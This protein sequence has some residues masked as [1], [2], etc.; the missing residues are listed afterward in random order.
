[1]VGVVRA[2]GC[3]GVVLH[4]ERRDVQAAQALDDVVVETDVAD[5][6][7]AERRVHGPVERCVDR[8]AVV[9]RGDLDAPVARSWTG[10]LMPRWP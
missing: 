6:G 2:G 5:L 9:V 10:W 8:E 1:V 3:L 4:R 7:T